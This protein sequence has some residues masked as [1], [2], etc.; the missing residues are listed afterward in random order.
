MHFDDQ[1]NYH[2]LKNIVIT[3]HP[4]C[5]AKY[6][7]EVKTHYKRTFKAL[8]KKMNENEL[9]SLCIEQ[10]SCYI[11]KV[12]KCWS[13]H[14]DRQMQIPRT[15]TCFF[16]LWKDWEKLIMIF[17][18]KVVYFHWFFQ[19]CFKSAFIVRFEFIFVLSSNILCVL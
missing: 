6:E 19:Q 8:L 12:T 9:L 2:I 18:V 17:G 1:S 13:S 11:H 14:L 15:W 10:F 3:I 5:Y 4:E 16:H 7:N